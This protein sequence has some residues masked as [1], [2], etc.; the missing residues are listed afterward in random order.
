MK[1]WFSYANV[2]ATIAVFVAL[3]GSSYAAIQ[4][5]SKQI[6]DNSVR[7]KDIRDD[8]VRGKDV[9][10]RSLL[11]RDFKAGQ[12]PRGPTGPAGPTGP[13]GPAG[14]STGP[15]GGD[16]SGTY[17]NPAVAAGAVTGGS[18]GKVADDSLTGADVLES[19]LGKVADADTLDGQDSTAF[20]ERR[21]AVVRADGSLARGAGGATSSRSTTGIYFVNFTGDATACAYTAT[22]G[23]DTN[24]TP[25][26]APGFAVARNGSANDVVVLT[27]NTAGASTD[28][29]FHLAVS[30]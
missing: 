12:I 30:C 16:L 9:R 7:S 21:W 22:L 18:G 15:A 19:S 8:A 4:I 24:S 10:D 26:D 3:G 11:A 14:P 13:Q 5:G 29:G 20:T 23:H 25:N 1:Q 17:P 28:R 27:Y 2:M 6:A